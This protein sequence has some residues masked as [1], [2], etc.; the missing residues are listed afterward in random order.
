TT[1][2]ITTYST[3][4]RSQ[5][6]RR[7]DT[8]VAAT[9]HRHALALEQR[10]IAVR[11]IGHALVLVLLLTGHVDIAPACTGGQDHRAALDRAAIGEL[12]DR[13]STRLYS[14]HLK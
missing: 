5:V 7:L 4:F 11:A 2:P 8:G 13:K 1:H 9:N 3:L 14:S 6:D 12:E 10:A